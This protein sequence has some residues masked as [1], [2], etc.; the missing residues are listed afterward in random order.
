MIEK[1]ILDLKEKLNYYSYKYYV[2]D[3]SE[4]SDFEYDKLYRR[5]E[6]L[7]N[8]YP[9]YKTI[10]SPTMRIGGK[11]LDEFTKV[12]HKHK[13]ESLADV[14]SFGELEN[15]DARVREQ[16]GDDFTYV[17]EKKIDGLSVSIRYE[18]GVLV[19]A[20]TRGDGNIG[21][22]VT[23]NILTIKSVP[24]KLKY[25]VKELEVRGEVFMSKKNFLKLN[26]LQEINGENPFANPRNAAAG[27]L[28]QLDPKVAAKRN[29]DIFIFNLQGIDGKELATHIE[30]L[31]YLKEQGF[32]V[33]PGYKECKDIRQVI[34]Y[35][36]EIGEQRETLPFDIDGAVIKINSLKQREELGSTIKVPKWAVAYK[37]PAEQKKTK[38]LDIIANVGRTGVITP[39]AILEP[40]NL[41]GST[42]GRATL[43]N[44]DY[45]NEKD[46]RIGD[47]VL[48]QKAGDIIPEVVETVKEERKGSEVLFDMPRKCPVCGADVVK[49]EG[50]VAYRCTG[51]ECRAQI[52]RS[53]IHFASRN[54]M[55][56]EGIGPQVIEVLF[57]KGYIKHIA[58]LYEL[59]KKREELEKIDR[60]G[61]KSVDNMLRFIE[62]SKG[63]NIDRL[64]FGF[65]IRHVG[66]RAAQLLSQ[67]IDDLEELFTKTKEE[68]TLID[69]L[70][71]KI[72]DSIVTFFKQEQT[73]DIVNRL[74]QNGVNLKS[75]KKVIVDE[76]FKDMT[77]VLTGKLPTYSRNE[78]SDII[79]K[80]GGKVSGS[81][82]KKTT[83][84][85][86]GE[87][88]GSKLD[89]AI[90][91]NIK[92]I[93]EDEFNKMCK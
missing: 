19:R 71:D 32:K 60:L 16:L 24:I 18:D 44:L 26:E 13:M 88:G 81:V 28:R 62:K 57:E 37:Y 42:V 9:E 55:N 50:E 5:L 49:E 56:I 31:E 61:K 79:K 93:D 74:K 78:A 25:P 67:N 91:L 59:Y 41:A 72:A 87:D 43:H 2:E 58:D 92:I 14:F 6:E 82:S 51:I 10:D 46:I 3:I 70:G 45:I 66:L 76:R 73:R 75:Q 77:F 36:K 21:E 7:E 4:I 22:D 83:Y 29:L 84:V 64:L 54:A 53:I 11:P 23:N 33:S 85:L 39:V 52:L 47:T 80:Y 20:A 12:V 17:V 69:E 63:N 89:K 86:A 35:I 38:I 34:E 48:I 65:G 30:P 90:E 15:F 68:I 1:E 40:V 27:S 8:Q